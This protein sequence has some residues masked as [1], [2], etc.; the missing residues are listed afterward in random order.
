MFIHI[1]SA[2]ANN[3]CVTYH[4]FIPIKYNVAGASHMFHAVPGPCT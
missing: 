4:M 3:N 2:D 1:K